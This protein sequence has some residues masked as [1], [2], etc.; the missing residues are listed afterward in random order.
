MAAMYEVPF[1]ALDPILPPFFPSD[2]NLV[3]SPRVISHFEDIGPTYQEPPP[4][5]LPSL[6]LSEP[7]ASILTSVQHISQLTTSTNAAYPSAAT[8]LVILTRLMFLLSH[9]LSLPPITASFFPNPESSGA[10]ISALVTE[11]ARYAILLHV[12]TPWRGLPPDGTLTINHLLHQM[13]SSLKALLSHPDYANN[14]LLLWIFAT[15]GVSA[16]NM[17][18]RSW[19]V[20]HLAD[21]TQE[22]EI[23]TWEEMKACVS[24]GIWHERLVGRAHR[25]LWD[26]IEI[27]KKVLEEA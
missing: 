17:P 15:G 8:H 16:L 2:H 22:M 1:P 11:S 14:I 20:S 26:E 24:R 6:G 21:M 10:Q 4:L 9:L 25:K 3:L 13:I 19:F 18:E 12:F 5:D 7:I 27:K 23:G